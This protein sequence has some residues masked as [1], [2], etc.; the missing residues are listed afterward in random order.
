MGADAAIV[1]AATW[2]AALAAGYL[3]VGVI[4]RALQ[5]RVGVRRAAL[6]VGLAIAA[7]G[8]GV[9]IAQPNSESAPRPP[10]VSVDWPVKPMHTRPAVVAPGDS[11]WTI[12]A[13]RIE[14]PTAARVAATWPRWWHTNRRVVGPDPNYIRPGQRLRP[15]VPIR[16]GS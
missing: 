6:G 10:A 4:A 14:R 5:N 11:L 2:T 1:A 8:G 3:V 15:P 16:S 13:H 7:T 12:A 9:A